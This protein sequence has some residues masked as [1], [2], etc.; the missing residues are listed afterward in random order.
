MLSL[1]SPY[2]SDIF[3]FFFL[4]STSVR[5]CPEH[6]SFLTPFPS[7]SPLSQIP[8]MWMALNEL[9]L[10]KSAFFLKNVKNIQRSTKNSWPGLLILQIR[11]FLNQDDFLFFFN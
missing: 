10:F 3:I 6:L 1:S 8:E 11:I 5:L 4:I 2:T 9:E 7:S